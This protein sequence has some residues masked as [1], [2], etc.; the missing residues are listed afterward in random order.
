MHSEVKEV[1]NGGSTRT[2]GANQPVLVDSCQLDII[3]L[4]FS[5]SGPDC[6]YIVERLFRLVGLYL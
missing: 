5:V 2:R 6:V 1:T 4:V 3:T